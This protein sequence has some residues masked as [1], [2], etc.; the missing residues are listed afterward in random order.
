MLSLVDGVNCHIEKSFVSCQNFKF[1]CENVRKLMES[2]VKYSDHLS[3]NTS[4]QADQR[5]IDDEIEPAY[6][7]KLF[8]LPVTPSLTAY[9]TKRER[10]AL[11]LLLERLEN[12]D[13]YEPI[14]VNFHFYERRSYRHV[15]Y[16]KLKEH[17]MK[18]NNV[19][20]FAQYCKGAMGN[21]YFVWR[22]DPTSVDPLTNRNSNVEKVIQNLP[23][24]FSRSHKQKVRRLTE[25]VMFNKTSQAQFRFIHRE[26]TGDDNRPKNNKQA[27]YDER[28]KVIIK[29]SD[30]SLLSDFRV[31]NTKKQSSINF[32]TLLKIFWI[33]TV[34]PPLLPY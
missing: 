26:I 24:Y 9:K 23:K 32:G 11:Q 15:F 16:K 1:V 7:R 29:N 25:Q 28:I 19:I 30:E 4:L 5:N 8:E 3:Q 6:E 2:C 10:D 13:F 20:L 21:K 17:A 18:I 27:E 12:K 22:E 33:I 31:N 34:E 14:S